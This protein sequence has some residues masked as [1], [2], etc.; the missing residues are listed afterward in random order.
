MSAG[1]LELEGYTSVT[2]QKIIYG[3]LFL[4]G[5]RGQSETAIA[6]FNVSGA[7]PGISKGR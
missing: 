3:E 4:F 5:Y 6:I 1:G 2:I 7:H